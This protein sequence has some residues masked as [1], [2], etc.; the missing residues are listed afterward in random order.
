MD[1]CAIKQALGLELSIPVAKSKSR[2]MISWV[3]EKE[4]ESALTRA[5]EDSLASSHDFFNSPVDKTPRN[6]AER[7]GY[8]IV[9]SDS[10]VA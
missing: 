8:V 3:F 5:V 4:D 1:E 10:S 6:S 9:T 7:S 2:A